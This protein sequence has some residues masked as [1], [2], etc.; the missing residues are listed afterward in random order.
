MKTN[1]VLIASGK[2]TDLAARSASAVVLMPVTLYCIWA[3][4]I[5]FEMFL[6]GLAVL[7]AYE[8]VAIVHSGSERSLALH[9][10]AGLA[11]VL[12]TETQGLDAASAAVL[13]LWLISVLMWL[14]RA[15][16]MNLKSQGFLSRGC[17]I[18]I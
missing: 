10:L 11:G 18:T 5:W 4:G 1:P 9:V 8:W 13:I 16:V 3:G 12:V 17:T 7:I 6:G 2:W 15:G 14:V